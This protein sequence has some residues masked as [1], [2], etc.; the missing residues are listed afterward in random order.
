MAIEIELLKLNQLLLLNILL[1]S[2]Y[3]SLSTTFVQMLQNE[4]EVCAIK[5]LGERT[6]P[7]AFRRPVVI[8]G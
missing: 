5:V 2:I 1:T 3:R 4:L 8:H 7:L 6:F